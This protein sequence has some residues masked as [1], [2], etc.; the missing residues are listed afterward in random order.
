M[1]A[2][3]NAACVAK[4]MM[5]EPIITPASQLAPGRGVGRLAVV[6]SLCM[7]GFPL[8]IQYRRE[9]LNGTTIR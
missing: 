1:P 9:R 4:V 3:S 7:A 2:P 5:A 6:L 8:I